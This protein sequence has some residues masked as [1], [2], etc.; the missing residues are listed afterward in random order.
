MLNI[1]SCT[2]LKCKVQ[3]KS[4]L[5]YGARFFCYFFRLLIRELRVESHLRELSPVYVL[6]YVEQGRNPDLAHAEASLFVRSHGLV[7]VP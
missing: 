3:G 6:H 2:H 1:R 4:I 7:L 5:F